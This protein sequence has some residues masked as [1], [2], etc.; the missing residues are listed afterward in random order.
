MWGYVGHVGT[1]TEFV[2]AMTVNEPPPP[3]D[4]T[5][6][7]NG[8]KAH[9]FAIN[10][11]R[12]RR[13]RSGERIGALFAGFLGDKPGIVTIDFTGDTQGPEP[14]QMRAI[15]S[16]GTMAYGIWDQNA[17][18]TSAKGIKDRMIN[19][20]VEI[21]NRRA[22]SIGPPWDVFEIKPISPQRLTPEWE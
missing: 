10:E 14:L 20:F 8:A 21:C 19:T 13:D 5:P 12:Y 15:G 16:V 7:I 4:W 22:L 18:D 17:T 6:F 3:T 11:A 2:D 1:G 9:L